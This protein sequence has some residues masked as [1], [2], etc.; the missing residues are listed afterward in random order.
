M[1]KYVNPAEFLIKLSMRPKHYRHDL[2]LSELHIFSKNAIRTEEQQR[3]EEFEKV[4]ENDI[5]LIGENRKASFA[6]QFGILF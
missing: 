4:I 5:R 2:T 6:K 1:P 3:E